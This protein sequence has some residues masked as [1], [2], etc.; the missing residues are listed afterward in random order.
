MLAPAYV[1]APAPAPAASQGRQRMGKGMGMG[2]LMASRPRRTI[3]Y[4]VAPAAASHTDAAD[5]PPVVF[6]KDAAK[7]VAAVLEPHPPLYKRP[8]TVPIAGMAGLTHVFS[9]ST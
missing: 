4:I 9:R 5:A 7:W 6:L 8:P 3:R 2:K 1:A